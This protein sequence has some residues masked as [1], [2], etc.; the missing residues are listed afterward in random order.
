MGMTQLMTVFCKSVHVFSISSIV[1]ALIASSRTFS[2]QNSFT[3]NS[4]ATKK[5]PSFDVFFWTQSTCSASIYFLKNSTLTN[6]ICWKRIFYNVWCLLPDVLTFVCG[7][8]IQA[9]SKHIRMR[10]GFLRLEIIIY[11]SS[12]TSKLNQNQGS[13]IFSGLELNF[14][15]QFPTNFANSKGAFKNTFSWFI[16]LDSGNGGW[17]FWRAHSARKKSQNL[18][19]RLIALIFDRFFSKFVL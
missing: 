17:L 15:T 1:T 19:S 13:L 5:S 10:P 4:C 12:Q 14:G 2:C 18:Q 9:N 6:V 7:F 16:A 8:S 11:M 3:K